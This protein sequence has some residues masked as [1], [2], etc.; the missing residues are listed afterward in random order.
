[1]CTCSSATSPRPHSGAEMSVLAP[2]LALDYLRLKQVALRWGFIT[3]AQA[4]NI[5]HTLAHWDA[6]PDCER[7]HVYEVLRRLRIRL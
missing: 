5:E 4:E 3:S 2:A 1:M 6:M 7:D